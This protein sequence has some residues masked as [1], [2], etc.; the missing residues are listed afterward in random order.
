MVTTVIFSQMINL[1][2][3]FYY[4]VSKLSII[5]FFLFHGPFLWIRFNH[6]KATE[7]LRGDTLLLSLH[8]LDWE[9]LAPWFIKLV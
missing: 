9:L 6:L 4:T 8:P 1:F 3:S 2:K 5:D 7:A